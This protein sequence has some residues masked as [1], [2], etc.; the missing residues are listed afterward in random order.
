MKGRDSSKPLAICVGHVGSI[1]KYC[2]VTVERGVL[3]EL[4]PGAVTLIFPRKSSLNQN[5]NPGLSSIGV[6]IP[7]IEFMIQ[8]AQAADEALA[9]TSANLSGETSALS[10]DEFRPLWQHLGCIVNGGILKSN[11]RSG[12]TVVDL[13]SVDKTDRCNRYKIVR[14]G[15]ALIETEKVLRKH[16]LVP[17]D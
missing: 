6:R 16:G 7:R 14:E 9:L 11:S 4:Y 2:H 8:I 5:L 15:C 17:V 10:V 3:E 12:S 1:Y 13:S